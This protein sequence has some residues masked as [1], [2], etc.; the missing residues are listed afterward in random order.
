MKTNERIVGPSWREHFWIER[1]RGDLQRERERKKEYSERERILDRERGSFEK[2]T[3]SKNTGWRENVI[4]ERK[5][6]RSTLKTVTI[7]TTKK[8]SF[9]LSIFLSL[10]KKWIQ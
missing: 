2:L 1:E 8:D 7:L 3:A 5:E 4:M 10:P 9:F 6:T